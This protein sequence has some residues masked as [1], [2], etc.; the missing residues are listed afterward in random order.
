[1]D[2]R[3]FVNRE[4]TMAHDR[5]DHDHDHEDHDHDHEVDLFAVDADGNRYTTRPDAAPGDWHHSATVL[6]PVVVEELRTAG[7][8]PLEQVLPQ[9]ES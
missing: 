5:E 1:L 9:Y 2:E 4:A 7:K 8:L 6:T 3:L